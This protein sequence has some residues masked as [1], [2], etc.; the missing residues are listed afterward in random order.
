MTIE[1]N[2]KTYLSETGRTQ[3]YLSRKTGIS[4]TRLSL[5]FGEKRKL[6]LEEYVEICR[7][8]GLP[9]DTFMQ[10]GAFN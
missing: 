8:L 7:A 10:N 4:P 1:K 9:L 3:A 6:K 5:A 2:I